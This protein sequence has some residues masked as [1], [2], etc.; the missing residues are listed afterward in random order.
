MSHDNDELGARILVLEAFAMA[1]LGMSLR[2]GKS[3]PPEQVI[4]ILD[5]AKKAVVA[6]MADKAET[7]SAAG[8]AE[9]HR[10]LDFLMSH[11]SEWLI[12][13][14]KPPDQEPRTERDKD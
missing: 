10:Y 12:P 1:A 5:G 7:L 4:G 14:P 2:V 6:R 8:E 13:K 11:F 9:A 3:I